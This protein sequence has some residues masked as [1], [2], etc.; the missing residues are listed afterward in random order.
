MYPA[1]DESGGTRLCA[2]SA[3]RELT[4]RY[5]R[6]DYSE[7]I[8]APQTPQKVN[9]YWLSLSLAVPTRLWKNSTSRMSNASSSNAICSL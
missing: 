7:G 9:I 8:T 3:P 1:A 4:T 2:S 6:R 5:D